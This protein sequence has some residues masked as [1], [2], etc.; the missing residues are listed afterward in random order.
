[1]ICF[2]SIAPFLVF[3]GCILQPSLEKNFPM[4]GKPKFLTQTVLFLDKHNSRLFAIT[5][6]GHLWNSC[7]ASK[8]KIV[9]N[10]FTDLTRTKSSFNQANCLKLIQSS[11][12]GGMIYYYR[13]MEPFKLEKSLK[14]TKSSH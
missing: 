14:I 6:S 4:S 12:Y 13:I 3:S 2:Y 10:S 11:T 1:M 7:C 9:T 8:K 5:H